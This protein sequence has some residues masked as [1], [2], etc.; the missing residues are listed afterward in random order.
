MKE[1][2]LL[3]AFSHMLFAKTNDFID[4]YYTAYGRDPENIEA[5]AYDTAGIIF[6]T[7]ET[8]GIQTRQ[9]LVSSL[10]GTE[11]YHGATGTV[12]FGYDRV[13]HKNPF[14]FANKNGKLEQMK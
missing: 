9:E 10:M 5:L 6:N 8:K 11:N 3:T 14:Y 12:S 13:A 1:R 4:I 2:F 7:I